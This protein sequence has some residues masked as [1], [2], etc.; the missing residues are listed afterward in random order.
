MEKKANPVLFQDKVCR[1]VKRIIAQLR[2]GLLKEL[3]SLRTA[4]YSS[5]EAPNDIVFE[6]VEKNHIAFSTAIVASLDEHVPPGTLESQLLGDSGL[7]TTLDLLADEYKEKVEKEVEVWEHKTSKY[8][9]VNIIK[10]VAYANYKSNSR[11]P[12]PQQMSANCRQISN[13]SNPL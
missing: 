4:I 10:K 1:A 12:N 11:Q 3:D 13:M 7:F 5:K 8:S 9:E 2:D 6:S